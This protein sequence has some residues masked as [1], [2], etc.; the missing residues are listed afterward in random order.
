M[1]ICYHCLI[2]T[3]HTGGCSCAFSRIHINAITLEYCACRS[4]PLM[5]RHTVCL[6]LLLAPAFI[7]LF[8]TLFSRIPLSPL[9]VY[10]LALLYLCHVH[11]TYEMQCRV[12][13]LLRQHIIADAIIF[14]FLIVYASAFQK[15][16]YLLESTCW[17]CFTYYVVI[18]LLCIV[19]IRSRP[20][21]LSPP[22]PLRI[23]GGIKKLF[24]AIA[25][26]AA[27]CHYIIT[28]AT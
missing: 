17:F 16:H 19:K 28:Y 6:S 10:L 3:M 24:I 21:L 20:Y 8:H 4:L 5:P 9:H 18:I 12:Y 1:V 7:L 22:R 27:T 15:R 13:L 2:A 11:I 26:I 14:I 25:Y 23:V